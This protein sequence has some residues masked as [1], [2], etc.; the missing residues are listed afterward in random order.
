LVENLLQR[1]DKLSALLTLVF[2]ESA[3]KTGPTGRF[4][5]VSAALR[6]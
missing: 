1:A 2:L 4:A 3:L 6:R 5:V